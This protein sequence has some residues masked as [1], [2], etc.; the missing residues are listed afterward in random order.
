LFLQEYLH[1]HN[2]GEGPV[3]TIDATDESSHHEH[4]TP[5][6]SENV[7]FFSTEQSKTHSRTPQREDVG[8]PS[9][10]RCMTDHAEQ[11]QGV[12]ASESSID[13][14]QATFPGSSHVISMGT[15]QTT[16]LVDENLVPIK[17]EKIPGI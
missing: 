10:A 12:D 2:P 11:G 15:I 14:A 8:A 16:F 17:I 5:R 3:A 7:P 4:L 13:I 1:P 9:T 6:A